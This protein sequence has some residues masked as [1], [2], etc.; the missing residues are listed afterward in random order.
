MRLRRRRL[1][2]YTWA[3]DPPATGR[4]ARR[5]VTWVTERRVEIRDLYGH[6]WN[7]G[8]GPRV[9][10]G[11]ARRH[12]DAAPSGSLVSHRD[13]RRGARGARSLG[14]AGRRGPGRRRGTRQAPRPVHRRLPHARRPEPCPRHAGRRGPSLRRVPDVRCTRALQRWG[15]PLRHHLPSVQA[16][17]DRSVVGDRVSVGVSPAQ[18]LR[19]GSVDEDCETLEHDPPW[20]TSTQPTPPVSPRDQFKQWMRERPW[21]AREVAGLRAKFAA[22]VEDYERV[23]RTTQALGS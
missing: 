2:E 20:R 19:G 17:R 10:C 1:R 12:R 13:E 18:P 14:E 22:A 4:P 9:V 8:M 23:Y 5:D 11:Q 6:G 16:P 15:Y 3:S 21:L 7:P